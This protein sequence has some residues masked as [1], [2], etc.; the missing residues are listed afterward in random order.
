[1]DKQNIIAAFN[2]S[3]EFLTLKPIS[4]LQNFTSYNILRLKI[5]NTKFGP[6]LF[7]TLQEGE[8]KFN[9]FLPKRYAKKLT[10]EMIQTINEGDFNL[11][12][13]GGEYHEVEIE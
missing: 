12:Y 9:I 4:E 2:K 13:I 11:R 10:S 5:I 6:S 1:M 7:A 8:D 3:D